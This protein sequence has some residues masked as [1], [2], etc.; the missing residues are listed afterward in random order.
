MI[1][2][3]AVCPRAHDKTKYSFVC[4]LGIPNKIKVGIWQRIGHNRRSKDCTQTMKHSK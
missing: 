1:K 2:T 4:S 3:Y